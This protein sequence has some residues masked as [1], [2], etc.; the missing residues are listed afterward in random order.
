M[1][2]FNSQKRNSKTP[3][4]RHTDLNLS[5]QGASFGSL[6]L[7]ALGEGAIVAAIS[8]ILAAIGALVKVFVK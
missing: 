5:K 1:R 7:F 2:A 8:S 3:L 4:R 6:L